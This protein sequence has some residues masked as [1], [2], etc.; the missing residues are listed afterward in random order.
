MAFIDVG[1]LVEL[2]P[3][4]QGVH[5]LSS[6]YSNGLIFSNV[7]LNLLLVAITA[8]GDWH[9]TVLNRR[10]REHRYDRLSHFDIYTQ[11]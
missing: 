6:Q 11:V 5:Q 10:L 9:V 3:E 2:G 4:P 1:A 7:V 8:I